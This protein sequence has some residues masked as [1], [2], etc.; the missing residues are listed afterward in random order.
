[1]A[2]KRREEKKTEEVKEDTGV[3]VFPDGSRYDGQFVR[4]VTTH[5]DG[6]DAKGAGKGAS[7]GGA[8]ANSNASNHDS[9]SGGGR[10]SA[11]PTQAIGDGAHEI[12]E[13]MCPVITCANGVTTAVVTYRHG[14]GVF[15]DGATT[16]DGTWD[17]DRMHGLGRLRT[18][19]GPSYTGYFSN[20]EFDGR[21]TYAWPD[22]SCYAGQWRAN[23][24]H[25]EGTYTDVSGKRWRGRFYNGVGERLVEVSDCDDS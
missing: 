20:N 19:R 2:P 17:H 21:G 23:R 8:G 24:M 10:R 3:F 6:D 18:E 15:V 16:Y 25:G 7:A 14:N 12:A 9:R 4:M 1:M 22:G 5:D 13:S 11:T